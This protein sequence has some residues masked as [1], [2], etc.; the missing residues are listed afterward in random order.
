M[1]TTREMDDF[2]NDNENLI[3]II[4]DFREFFVSLSLGISEYRCNTPQYL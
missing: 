1:F 2:D 3:C 4:H